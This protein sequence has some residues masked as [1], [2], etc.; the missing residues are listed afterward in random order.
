LEG[1]RGISVLSSAVRKGRAMINAILVFFI[2]AV[3]V[4]LVRIK[5]HRL[6]I[7][8]SLS[9]V[10]ALLLREKTLNAALILFILN[11]LLVIA[12]TRIQK[13]NTRWTTFIYAAILIALDHW[14]KR[15]VPGFSYVV[16][17]G[18]LDLF[19]ALNFPSQVS[20]R[21]SLLN[22]TYFPKMFVGPIADSRNFRPEAGAY[23]RSFPLAL[24]G[25]IKLFVILPLFTAEFAPP[26]WTELTSVAGYFGFG[27]WNYVNLYLE[28]S[29]STDLVIA[30]LMLFGMAL[31]AN[32]N[33]PYLA[34]SVSEFWLRWHMSLGYWIRN[35]VYIPLGGNRAGVGRTYLNLI[36]AMT[37]CGAWHGVSANF[38]GWGLLQGLLMAGERWL[39][40]GSR[41]DISPLRRLCG[42]APHSG[43]GNCLMDFVLC[44]IAG[45]SPDNPH[46]D[47]DR[48]QSERSPAHAA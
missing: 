36:L 35:H 19:A 39:G 1:H 12:D 34:L 28:F 24:A 45:R 16:L 29:G 46:S 8:F 4:S 10:A 23:E 31:P 14:L 33:R 6:L 15:R 13:L 48:A 17:A 30:S 40:V 7:L 20:W 27:L 18:S 22:L 37:I 42:V 43:F 44:R 38:I 5:K 41:S 9:L 32:F 11:R 3:L 47:F 25:I 21:E 26:K 2:V